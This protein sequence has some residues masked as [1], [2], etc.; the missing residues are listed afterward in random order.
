MKDFLLS[1]LDFFE[2]A[3]LK[4]LQNLIDGLIGEEGGEV[5]SFDI[6]ELFEFLEDLPETLVCKNLSLSHWKIVI[7]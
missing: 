6:R 2:N 3:V 5:F 1:T 4:N 7:V